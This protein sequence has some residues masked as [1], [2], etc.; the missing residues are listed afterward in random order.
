MIRRI[1]GLPEGVLGFQAQGRVSASD[2]A[3][4]L[5]PAV[6]VA[7]KQ[8]DKLRLLYQIGPEFT[9]FDAGAA[10]DDMRVGLKHYLSWEKLA[11][12]SDVE[13]IRS[14]AAL[15]GALMPAQVRIFAN[16]ELEAAKRWVSE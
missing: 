5:T 9:G 2:Y 13:W 15:F 4:V 12:V 14:S 7:F 3:T 8:R 1:E 16:G 10:W 11:L 6:E